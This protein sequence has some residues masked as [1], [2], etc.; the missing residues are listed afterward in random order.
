MLHVDLGV[1]QEA[2]I[3]NDLKL[4]VCGAV[5]AV[6]DAVASCSRVPCQERQAVGKR[7]DWTVC[8][9]CLGYKHERIERLN[10]NNTNTVLVTG[11]P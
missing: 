11:P 7:K 6:R 5:Y 1:F 4:Q 8:I 3:L 2:Q 9:P 10:F